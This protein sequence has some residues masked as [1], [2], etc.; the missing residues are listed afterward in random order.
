MSIKGKKG[1]IP[2]SQEKA[3]RT[4]ESLAML[5]F[6][7]EYGYSEVNPVCVEAAEI[8]SDAINNKKHKHIA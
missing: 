5:M 7:D 2:A 4:A 1:S 8:V 3:I 6:D